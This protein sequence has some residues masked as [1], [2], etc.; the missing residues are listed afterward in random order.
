VHRTAVAAPGFDARF[1]AVWRR[2][3]YRIA[4]LATAY[5]PSSEPA[6]PP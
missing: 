2:Y 5:D 3:E 4:D 6:R 1:S